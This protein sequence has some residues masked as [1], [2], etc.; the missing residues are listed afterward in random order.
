MKD[1]FQLF[2]QKNRRDT[3]IKAAIIGISAAALVCGALLLTAKI[4]DISMGVCL[5][6]LLALPIGAG[7]FLLFK[8]ISLLQFAKKLDNSFQLHEKVQTMV[9]FEHSDDDMVKIQ[10]ADTLKKLEAIP[11]K[12]LR[13]GHLWAYILLPIMAAAM[14]VTAIAYP[15]K[16]DEPTVDPVEPPAVITDWEWAALDDLIDYVNRSEADEQIM[17]PRTR[18]ALYTLKNLL[19]DGVAESSL[20]GVVATTVTAVNNARQTAENELDETQTYQKQVNEEVCE[21]T[22]SKLYEIFKID[23]TTDDPV[24]PEPGGDDGNEDDGQNNTWDGSGELNMGA[25]DRLYDALEGYVAYGKVIADY[26]NEIN[27]A[28]VDGVLTQ[29]QYDYLM[30][31]FGYLYAGNTD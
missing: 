26:Q 18:N 15:Q 3:L 9:A 11:R 30:A 14:M 17:K 5:L 27:R 8:R 1:P 31:Y 28:F 10:R 25:D 4:T 13:F 6:G 12:K 29:A 21:Y 7:L 22:V 20:Q 24:D 16:P 23:A 2:R 19:L